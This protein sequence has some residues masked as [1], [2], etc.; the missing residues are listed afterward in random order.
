[1]IL[2]PETHPAM[3]GRRDN[4]LIENHHDARLTAQT[5][6][7]PEPFHEGRKSY[8]FSGLRLRQLQKNLASAHIP[9]QRFAQRNIH[10]HELPRPPD[11]II[12]QES[13]HLV[14]RNTLTLSLA[15]PAPRTHA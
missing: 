15:L 4:A 5:V 1:M 14:Q 11:K 10:C 8:S 13:P 7:Y 2:I 3:F 9:P 12:S 6:T